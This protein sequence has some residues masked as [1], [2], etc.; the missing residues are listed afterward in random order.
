MGYGGRLNMKCDECD[1]GLQSCDN[2]SKKFKVD[3]Q[4]WCDGMDHYCSE[5][6]ALSHFDIGE[7]VKGD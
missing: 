7:V 1:C 3:N 4:V 5:N 6:C 2:C